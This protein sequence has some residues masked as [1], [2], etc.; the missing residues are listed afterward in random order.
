M[1]NVLAIAMMLAP[2]PAA[3]CAEH[4]SDRGVGGVTRADRADYGRSMQVVRYAMVV[5]IDDYKYN[6][7]DDLS[8]LSGAYGDAK[9]FVDFLKSD[10]GRVPPEHVAF[11]Y[12]KSAT[13]D[14]II[15]GLEACLGRLPNDRDAMFV[16]YFAGHGLPD[17]LNNPK[18]FF[19]APH[20]IRVGMPSTK[21]SFG[22]VVDTIV[23]TLQRRREQLDRQ[24][25]NL[26][27]VVVLI[28]DCCHSGNFADLVMQRARKERIAVLCACR[29]FQ[30]AGEVRT[31]SGA[32][33]LFTQALLAGLYGHADVREPRDGWI[34][35]DEIEVFVKKQ[36]MKKGNIKK[37]RPIIHV[38]DDDLEIAL[39]F[40]TGLE[41][42][43]PKPESG[44]KAAPAR[45]SGTKL[46]LAISCNE[47]GAAITING[48]RLKARTHSFQPVLVNVRPGIYHVKISRLFYSTFEQ[49]I[50]VG[51]DQPIYLVR[52]RLKSMA[53]LYTAA[54]FG[55]FVVLATAGGV[56][57][58]LMRQQPEAKA[59]LVSERQWWV[60]D[61]PEFTMGRAADNDAVVA[62]AAAS[63]HHAVIRRVADRWVIE[64]AR[65]ANGTF[66]NRSKVFRKTLSEGDKIRVASETFRFSELM[67][68]PMS[69]K[70]RSKDRSRRRSP[71]H[72]KR[73]Q[74]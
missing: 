25:Q 10:A 32:R 47:G 11:L 27:D 59:Y 17:D 52:A 40:K 70:R 38:P 61:K 49:E 20:D 18:R 21:I 45:V 37:Q 55:V 48:A 3:L 1:R 67:P 44:G 5:G 15:N 7:P 50:P 57:F 66:V 39:A 13:R 14:T 68:K 42:L 73:P 16:F 2:L 29:E 30:S 26:K 31:Q 19:L 58:V 74:R 28:F 34:D 36:F 43:A 72:Q 9:R 60:L 63:S 35:L 51:A 33:G 64:D 12:N 46:G 56:V 69:T 71:K 4:Q 6:G 54:G 53:A 24:Q 22:D 65:S 8:D 23:T 62:D 41:E